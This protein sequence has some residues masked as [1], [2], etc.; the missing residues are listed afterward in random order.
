M[1]VLTGS[2]S[3]YS[4]LIHSAQR[5]VTWASPSLHQVMDT[6]GVETMPAATRPCCAS[7]RAG[8]VFHAYRASFPVPAKDASRSPRVRRVH[9]ASN[10]IAKCHMLLLIDMSQCQHLLLCKGRKVPEGRGDLC[11]LPHVIASAQPSD[12]VAGQLHTLSLPEGSQSA[13]RP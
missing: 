1:P 10:C 9:G 3:G 4:V 11:A 2:A 13:G 5:A 6:S 8:H 12:E 7:L